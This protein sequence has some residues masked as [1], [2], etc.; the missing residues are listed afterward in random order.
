MKLKRIVGSVTAVLALTA[1]GMLYAVHPAKSSDHQDT[2]NLATR[3]NTSAD[4]TDVYVFPS[5]SN[6]NDVVFA[7]DVSPLI[8]PGTGASHFFDPTLM[9]QFKIAHGATNY[10]EDQVIQIGVNG[11]GASQTLSLY[12]PAA[13]NEVGTTNTFLQTASG[14]A[15]YNTS[16]SLQSGTVKLFG[17]PRTD[18]FFFDLFAFFTFAGDRNYGTHVSQSDPGPESAANPEGLCNGN[19]ASNISGLTPAYDKSPTNPNAPCNTPVTVASFN[20]FPSGTTSSTPIAP[21]TTASNPAL[22]TYACSTLPTYPASDTLDAGPFD[23]LSIVVEVPKSLISGAPYNTSLIHVW[24][25]VN[26]STG[27]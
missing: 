12:G 19:S 24:A 6:A 25:T 21:S 10:K 9:Y 27:S 4:I 5:P 7:M 15:P 11:T 16:T 14:T 18:P 20:G 13:P 26:S 1:A 2:Y 3:S 23:V 17:G 8:T 22:G